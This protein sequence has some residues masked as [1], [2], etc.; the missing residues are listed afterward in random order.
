MD[1]LFA[2]L[3]FITVVLTALSI[4]MRTSAAS[5]GA[6]LRSGVFLSIV[7]VN[8]VLVPLLGWAVVTMLPVP[9]SAAPGVLLCSIC[10]AGP[11]ALK[12]SQIARADLTWSLA[13]TVVLLV[14]NAVSLPLWSSMMIGE[15][16]ALRFSDLVAVLVAAI[17]LPVAIGSVVG[18]MAPTGADWWSSWS[19]RVSNVTFVLAVG[20][21]VAANIGEILTSL[22]VWLLL[23]ALV[24]VSLG[25]VVGWLV[26]TDGARRRAG[27]LT[28]LNRATSVALL[29]VARTFAGEGEMFT[30]IVVFGLVQTV[31][32][33]ALSL[34]WG[35]VGLGEP[36][37]A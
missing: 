36:V 35:R 10:A 11:I 30:A 6:A 29:V 2:G 27:S 19:T 33:L 31:V 17:V 28:T 32:A 1:G 24:I 8:V 4:G 3:I 14:L 9:T 15:T 25:G 21:G 22:S 37:S 7:A 26:V 12:A 23:A 5:L 18:G 16:V 34:Y 20:V 13:L